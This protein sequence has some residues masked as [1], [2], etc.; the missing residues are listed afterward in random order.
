MIHNFQAYAISREEFN[1]RRKFAMSLKSFI[2]IIVI[3]ILLSTLY[4]LTIGLDLVISTGQRL[5]EMG[6]KLLHQ[7]VQL[8]S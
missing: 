3:T 4:G 6:T 7:V 1:I 8:M 2:P 5:M